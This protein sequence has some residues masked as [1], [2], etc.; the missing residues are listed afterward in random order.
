M[1]SINK[2]FNSLLLIGC[3]RMGK[4]LL[5]G[6]LEKGLTADNIHIVDPNT[7]DLEIL[8]QRYSVK[9]YPRVE[10]IPEHFVPALVIMAVKPQ[11]MNKAIVSLVKFTHLG[12]CF[13]S[14]AA[15]KTISYFENKLGNTIPIVRAMP[16]IASTIGRG[17]TAYF[18]NCN[19]ASNQKIQIRQLLETVGEAIEV[20]NEE[21]INA[22]TALSGGGPAYVFLLI[23]TLAKAGVKSGLPEKMAMQLA[24]TT[25]I[26]SCELLIR[27]SSQEVSQLRLNVTSP[28]GTTAEALKILMADLT[29]IQPI[30]NTAIA[31]ATARS[32]I[33]DY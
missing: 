26:G 3:G 19:V 1:R 20:N 33:L 29:G 9:I 7:Q 16:N 30:F 8:S 24:R 11:M 23:E 15:G 28:G 13:L 31:A 14:V 17:I 12:A 25:V 10:E 21:Q 27:E 2:I 18:A 32:K 5:T 6:L 22:V 4:A